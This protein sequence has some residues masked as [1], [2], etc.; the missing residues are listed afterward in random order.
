MRRMSESIPTLLTTQQVA[1]RIG[2]HPQTVNRL[3]R[4]GRIKPDFQVNGYKGDRLY[5][6]ATVLEYLQ[7]EQH[8]S[9]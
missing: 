4:E 3:A 7:G 1:R 2:K 9:S 6:P 8:A 5:L